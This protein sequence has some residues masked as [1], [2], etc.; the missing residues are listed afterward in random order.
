M[1]GQATGGRFATLSQE[2]FKIIGCGC[3]AC[4]RVLASQGHYGAR[5]RSLFG[6]MPGG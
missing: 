1:A 3:V 5:F 6:D 2:A 4:G